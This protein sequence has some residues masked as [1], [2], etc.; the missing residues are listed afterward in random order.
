MSF[1]SFLEI[2]ASSLKCRID[3]GIVGKYERHLH[4]YFMY[5]FLNVFIAFGIGQSDRR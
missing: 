3:D 4:I 2:S 5:I 1:S